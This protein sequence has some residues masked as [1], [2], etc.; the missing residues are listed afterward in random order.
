[1]VI[2]V[3]SMHLFITLNVLLLWGVFSIIENIYIK[4]NLC[5]NIYE[6]FI[7]IWWEKKITRHILYF[8]WSFHPHLFSYGVCSAV[9]SK[10]VKCSW[11]LWKKL[12]S[13]PWVEF[14]PRSRM[15]F[16]PLS[17]SCLTAFI[18]FYYHAK[19]H[20]SDK[21]IKTSW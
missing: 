4:G 17:N 2:W 16:Q 1:M 13:G 7:L 19:H 9:M 14:F 12:V 20:A 11:K 5:K 10:I 15:N 6:I 8:F 3:K 18:V 21:S